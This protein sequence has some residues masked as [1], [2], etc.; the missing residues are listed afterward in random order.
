MGAFV[1]DHENAP[2]LEL[3]HEVRKEPPTRGGQPERAFHVAFQISNPVL[4]LRVI[5]DRHCAF[6]FLAAVA[7]LGDHRI[8][9]LVEA[10]FA[11]VPFRRGDGVGS[12]PEIEAARRCRGNLPP[13]AKVYSSSRWLVFGSCGVLNTQPR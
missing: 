4:D 13:S 5:V 1:L 12:R 6:E 10:P 7:K 11:L 8:E 9:M 3:T 2:V